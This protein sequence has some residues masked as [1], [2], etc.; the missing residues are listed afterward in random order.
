MR[1]KN[2]KIETILFHIEEGQKFHKKLIPKVRFL[3]GDTEVFMLSSIKKMGNL[4]QFSDPNIYVVHINVLKLII[5]DIEKFKIIKNF[6]KI[7]VVT[8]DCDTKK[9]DIPIFNDLN[10]AYFICEYPAFRKLL[11]AFKSV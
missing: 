3:L 2:K 5:N 8:S 4:E 7:I 10:I 9:R 1:N 11:K 6:K